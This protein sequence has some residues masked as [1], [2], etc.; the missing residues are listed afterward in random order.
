MFQE[1]NLFIYSLFLV[2]SL[3]R[4]SLIAF[5]ALAIHILKVA[6]KTKEKQSQEIKRML[7]LYSH[8]YAGSHES[9]NNEKKAKQL[10]LH[11]YSAIII[12]QHKKQILFLVTRESVGKKRR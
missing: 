11:F 12:Q 8:F 3:S 4:F 6:Q 10:K 7:L 5:S 2:V 9:G 1:K